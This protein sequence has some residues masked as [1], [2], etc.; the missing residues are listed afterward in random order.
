V[1]NQFTTEEF[2]EALEQM[3]LARNSGTTYLCRLLKGGLVR[4]LR[5]GVYEKTMTEEQSE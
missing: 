3:G 5:H 1:P 4:K 2:S